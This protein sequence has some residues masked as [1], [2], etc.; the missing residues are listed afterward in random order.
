MASE[1]EAPKKKLYKSF[2]TANYKKADVCQKTHFNW[3]R[4]RQNQSAY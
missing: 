3:E 4:F 1:D 2:L